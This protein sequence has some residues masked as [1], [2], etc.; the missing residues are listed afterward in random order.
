MERLA[1]VSLNPVVILDLGCATGTGSRRLER[2]YRGA[3]IIG[4]DLSWPMLRQEKQKRGWFSKANG[5]Q[6]NA[7]QL[8]LRSGSIDLVVANLL[9]PWVDL[10]SCLAEVTRVL[11][12]GGVFAFATLGPDSLGEIRKAWEAED[13]TGHVITYPDM[14]DIGDAVLRAGMRDPVL[15]V[16]RMSITYKS[17]ADLFRDLANAGAR[18]SLRSRAAHLTGKD[19]FQ[20]VCDALLADAR[21][22]QLA[23]GLE[24]VFGHAWGGGVPAAPGEFRLDP[25]AIGRRRRREQ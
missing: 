12:K 11:R 15:D 14:H 22:S 13:A 8:P 5:V 9:L 6:G 24:L 21:D 10:D 1:P 19:R 3:R 4:V 16:D 25:A 20:R 23:I 18:N 2:A 17:T 7:E